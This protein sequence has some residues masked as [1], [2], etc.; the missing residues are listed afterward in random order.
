M[1]ELWGSS[2]DNVFN[3]GCMG[4]MLHYDGSSWTSMETGI[5]ED[6]YAALNSVWGSS[7]DDVY[8][9]GDRGIIVHYECR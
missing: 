5:R 6:E 4:L 8:A 9:V 3:S 1:R 2:P 7:A